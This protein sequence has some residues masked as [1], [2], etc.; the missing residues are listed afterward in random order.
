MPATYIHRGIT[1]SVTSQYDD[2]FEIVI[3]LDGELI[4]ST[5]RTRLPELAKRR[6]GMLIN[7][8]LKDKIRLA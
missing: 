8:K 4:R 7:R 6:A 5:V 2:Q 3:E 1:F